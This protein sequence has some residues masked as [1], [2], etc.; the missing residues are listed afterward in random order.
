MKLMGFKFTKFN[1]EKKGSSIENLNIGTNIDIKELK[2]IKSELFKS[3][4]KL[5]EI[6]FNYKIEYNPEYALIE[7]KG[8]ILISLE[9]KDLKNIL[10]EWSNKKM[11]TDFKLY[12]FNLIIRKSSIKA[13]QFEEDLS[14]PYHMPFPSLKKPEENK[15]E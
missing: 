14:L 13:L 12:L 10:K 8:N 5:L 9:E 15:K 4:E 3:K 11:P 2:E 1:V 7:L 6:K